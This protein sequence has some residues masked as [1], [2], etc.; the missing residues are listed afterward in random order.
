MREK[1]AQHDTESA[2]NDCGSRIGAHF[3]LSFVS[4]T[5]LRRSHATQCSSRGLIFQTP[6][7]PTHR[8]AH[9][10]QA[11]GRTCTLLH[12]CEYCLTR[13]SK[14]FLSYVAEVGVAGGGGGGADGGLR[15][16]REPGALPRGPALLSGK[17]DAKC[18]Q[19]D[20]KIKDCKFFV[21]FCV[22]T[23]T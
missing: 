19:K 12:L 21:F 18:T 16:T 20:K 13:V 17:C 7:T 1:S 23:T 4:S 2:V 10:S 11:E 15:R 5:S 3:S 22:L 9:C 6:N 8:H 14:L